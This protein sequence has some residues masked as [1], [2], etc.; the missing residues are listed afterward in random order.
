[1]KL[2]TILLVAATL[3]GC[4][5]MSR[6]RAVPN[7]QLEAMNAKLSNKDCQQIDQYVK[8]AEDQL[9]YKGLANVNPE[10]LNDDDRKYNA[11]ARIMIWSLRIGCSNPDRYK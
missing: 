10:D 8:F 11:N 7:E 4:A 3:T 9:R 6:G 2:V 1:M 5:G